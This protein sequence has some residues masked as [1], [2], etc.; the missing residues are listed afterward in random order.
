MKKDDTLKKT[1]VK[2]K[3]TNC[4]IKNMKNTKH[5]KLDGKVDL[6]KNK[7]H[8]KNSVLNANKE[9]KLY[10][11][12]I[13]RSVDRKVKKMTT[14]EVEQKISLK[15]Q[16]NFVPCEFLNTTENQIKSKPMKPEK[17]KSKTKKTDK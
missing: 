12:N 5:L 10:V 17:K 9:K 15:K 11:F 6:N 2:F 1:F 8:V 4:N 14:N 3:D 13:N 16:L 7:A